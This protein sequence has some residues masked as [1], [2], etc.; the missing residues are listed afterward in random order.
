MDRYSSSAADNNFL[1]DLQIQTCVIWIFFHWLWI[2]WIIYLHYIFVFIE[3]SV[4]SLWLVLL[5]S[6]QVT[7]ASSIW[8]S[9]HTSHTSRGGKFWLCGCKWHFRHSIDEL[10][11]WNIDTSNQTN[12][13]LEKINC[14]SNQTWLTHLCMYLL[15]IF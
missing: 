2:L 1:H 3:L 5:V 12:S 6:F 14:F 8:D 13:R 9:R 7:V 11:F 15:E 10:F 4:C